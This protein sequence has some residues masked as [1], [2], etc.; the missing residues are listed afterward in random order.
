M[1]NELDELKQSWRELESQVQRHMA[2]QNERSNCDSI[3]NAC[4]WRR[5]V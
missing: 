3:L 5:E 2:Q 4:K 1:T